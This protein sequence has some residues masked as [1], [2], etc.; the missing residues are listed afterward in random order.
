MHVNSIEMDIDPAFHTV[1]FGYEMKNQAFFNVQQQEWYYQDGNEK[2]NVKVEDCLPWAEMEKI[3]SNCTKKCLPVVFQ[4]MWK[5]YLNQ[6]K[7][8][9][10]ADHF[11]MIKALD[12]PIRVSILVNLSTV[13]LCLN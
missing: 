13:P 12:N 9:I 2:Q 7:C 1:P 4:Y 11:C 8:H 6:T 3:S 10:G 5:D